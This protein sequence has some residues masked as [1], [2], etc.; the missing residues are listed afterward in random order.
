MALLLIAGSLTFM[1]YALQ[2]AFVVCSGC[3]A[4][5]LAVSGPQ[6]VWWHI[7]QVASPRFSRRSFAFQRWG[8]AS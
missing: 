3:T 2:V 5:S 6:H 8:G 1:A 4:P 7:A